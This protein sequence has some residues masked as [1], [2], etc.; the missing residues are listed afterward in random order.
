MKKFLVI[1]ILFLTGCSVNSVDNTILSV[2]VKLDASKGYRFFVDDSLVLD[3]KVTDA[4]V[5]KVERGALVQAESYKPSTGFL[6]GSE[7][8]ICRD[9]KVWKLRI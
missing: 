9:T 5:I 3:V 7:V 2:P 8:R 1:A 6:L 4:G